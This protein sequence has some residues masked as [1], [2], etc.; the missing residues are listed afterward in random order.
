[1]LICRDCSRFD[2]SPVAQ[3]CV[4]SPVKENGKFFEGS[5]NFL[6]YVY[7]ATAI[8]GTRSEF[9]MKACV[10]GFAKLFSRRK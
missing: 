4:A 2:A 8:P 5:P 6:V 7:A 3:C 9:S 1:M 10:P